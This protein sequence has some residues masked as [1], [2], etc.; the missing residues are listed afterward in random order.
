[1]KLDPEIVIG[2][3]LALAVCVMFWGYVLGAFW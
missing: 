2:W 3:T 1:M